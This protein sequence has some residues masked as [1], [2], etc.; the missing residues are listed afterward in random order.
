MRTEKLPF[1]INQVM[2][3]I[4]DA[5]KPFP[6]AALFQ[7]A[8]EGYSSAFEQLL[9]CILSTRT[10]DEISIICARN[11]FRLGRTPEEI[12]ELGP[13]RIDEAISSCRFHEAKAQDI[14]DI[15]RQVVREYGGV[16]PC[17]DTVLM[18]FR[19]IGPKCANLVLGIACGQT[20]ITVDVHVHRITNRWG[21][22]STKIPEQSLHELEKTLPKKYWVEINRLLVPFGKHICTARLPKCSTCPVLDMCR[23]VGVT[24]HR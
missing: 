1:D 5:V 14:S 21:Y 13:E 7:L 16:L 17:R 23:Q 24:R 10:L 2:S 20:R 8:H 19:G 18:S 6:K 15:A 9:A 4:R 3:L 12:A 22:I 11:L